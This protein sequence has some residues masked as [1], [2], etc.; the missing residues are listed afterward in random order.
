MMLMKSSSLY[1]RDS[2]VKTFHLILCVFIKY[3]L[4][5]VCIVLETHMSLKARNTVMVKLQQSETAVT[6][7]GFLCIY[8]H[9]P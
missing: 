7:L 9:F 6:G 8:V 2:V 3:L 4:C 5:T 1:I